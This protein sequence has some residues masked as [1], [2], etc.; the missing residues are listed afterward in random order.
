MATFGEAMSVSLLRAPESQLA[1]HG[2]QPDAGI[3][4]S[5]HRIGARVR[6][7]HRSL[8]ELADVHAHQGGR[9][10]AEV[11]QRRVAAADVRRVGEDPAE[12]VLGRQL[13]ERGAGVGD[14]GELAAGLSFSDR[15]C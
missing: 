3:L 1:E 15:C 5:R 13:L 9:H 11:A 4:V 6:H 8:E 7:L 14:R 10:Q 12:A 2:A